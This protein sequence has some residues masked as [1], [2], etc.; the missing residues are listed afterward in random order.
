MPPIAIR[1][2]IPTRSC[3]VSGTVN[4]DRCTL[5][6][7]CT[8]SSLLYAEPG[9]GFQRYFIIGQSVGD[10]ISDAAGRREICIGQ[11][12]NHESGRGANFKITIHSGGA[13]IVAE[14][15]GTLKG[16]IPEPVA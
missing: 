10:E 8:N 3:E 14:A 12:G 2:S 6:P 5:Q 9:P 4:D 7:Y 16:L 15:A 13:A 11:Y 1:A